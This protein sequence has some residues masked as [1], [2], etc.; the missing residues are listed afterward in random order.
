MK[1]VLRWRTR[2]GRERPVVEKATGDDLR[3]QHGCD[4]KREVIESSLK[5]YRRSLERA[6]QSVAAYERCVADLERLLAKE[7][8]Q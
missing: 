3:W 5:Q 4:T 7:P 1:Y 6:K 8:V 2:N